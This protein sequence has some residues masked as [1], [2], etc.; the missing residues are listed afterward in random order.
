MQPQGHLQVLLNILHAR[1]NPQQALDAPRICIGPGIPKS[2]SKGGI[3]GRVFVEDD[4]PVETREK[5]SAMGHDIRP[6][7]GFAR[8]LFGRGQVIMRLRGSDLGHPL[9]GDEEALVWAG[10]S[11]PRGDGQAVAQV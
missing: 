11:D 2:K 9:D 1:H 3:D 7:Q 6:L 5:L 8:A 10:G 4:L